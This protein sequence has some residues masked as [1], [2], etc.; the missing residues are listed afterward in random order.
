VPSLTKQN[1]NRMQKHKVIAL[2]KIK[3][4]FLRTLQ[5]GVLGWPLSSLTKQNLN[6]T[7]NHEVFAA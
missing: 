7:Q 5:G 2:I 3:R 4:T 6:R 1:L